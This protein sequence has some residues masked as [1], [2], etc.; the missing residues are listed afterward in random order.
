[1]G[2]ATI[3]G[4]GDH[5][6]HHHVLPSL[7]LLQPAHL[8]HYGYDAEF[9]L[10]P[11]RRPPAADGPP[12][13]TATAAATARYAPGVV[14][15]GNSDNRDEKGQATAGD[16]FGASSSGVPAGRQHHS[17]SP[18]AGAKQQ[19]QSQ[20]YPADALVLQ[21]ETLSGSRRSKLPLPPPAMSARCQVHP[22]VMQDLA[23]YPGDPVLAL[24]L[25]GGRS[26]ATTA[27]SSLISAAAAGSESVGGTASGV[28]KGPAPAADSFAPGGTSELRCLLCTIWAN[29]HLALAE[30]AIDGRI[31][32]PVPASALPVAAPS[33][34]SLPI[35]GAVAATTDCL[36]DPPSPPSD[37]ARATAAESRSPTATTVD[38]ST[39]NLIARFLKA[40]N[41]SGREVEKDGE[42]CQVVGIAPVRSLRKDPGT[43]TPA[44][45][46][47][48]R[49]GDA[50]PPAAGRISARV[51]RSS[52][53]HRG[54]A[55]G[56]LGGMGGTA[57]AAAAGV[58]GGIP[59]ESNASSLP[60]SPPAFEH[61]FQQRQQQR[62]L[63]PEYTSLLKRSLRHLVV[64]DGCE[65]AVPSCPRSTGTILE[66]PTAAGVTGSANGDGGGSGDG[67]GKEHL[68]ADGTTFLRIGIGDKGG[69]DGRRGEGGALTSLLG[70]AVCVV[71]PES[72]VLVES[73]EGRGV[74]ARDS[75]TE[76]GPRHKGVRALD[77]A[78]VGER[79]SPGNERQRG[80]EISREPRPRDGGNRGAGKVSTMTPTEA[81]MELMLLP[82]TATTPAK[83]VGGGELKPLE[84]LAP[85]GVLLTG[86]PGVGKTF[87][88]R[89]AVEAVR[90]AAPPPSFWGMGRGEIDGPFQVQLT[91]LNG[92]EILS[93]G[94]WEACQALRDAFSAAEE[95]SKGE[96]GKRAR[97]N[98][99]A[100][101][102][103][104][105]ADALL[106]R[107]AR[108]SEARD[109]DGD[110][111][112]GGEGA[113]ALAQ[114][115]TLMDGFR[116]AEGSSHVIVVGATNRP[117]ALDPALRRPGRFDRELALAPPDV[118]ER[119]D[120][121]RHHLRRV[122]VA[123]GESTM[124][125]VSRK[126]VGYVGAD[127]AALAREAA[128]LAARTQASR[129]CR[130]DGEENRPLAAASKEALV[131]PE[132]LSLAMEKVGASSL[133]GHQVT[134]P[135][136]PWSDIGGM[137]EAKA[138]LRQAVEWPVVHKASFDRMGLTPP[139]GILLFGPPGCSKTT[140]VRAAA[141][142]A[143]ATFVCLS[144]ADVFSPYLGEAEAEIRQAFRIARNAAPAILFFDEIDAI[145]CNRDGG[146]KASF[147]PASSAESRVLATFL[148]EMDGVGSLKGDGVVV[149]G[150]TNRP[151]A[152]DRALLRP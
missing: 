57:V 13:R 123:G 29:P 35:T 80:E 103:L 24:T 63:P 151:E 59:W 135:D 144:G 104:D 51:L 129:Q 97:G 47:A 53:R 21:R 83:A 86:P 107:R 55:V 79:G 19:Q 84:F 32:I 146:G 42:G 119:A 122:K 140:L 18:E 115:L 143:G 134:V 131:E 26:S 77:G 110:K 56:Y 49:G 23:L 100:V 40:A 52:R 99:C 124:E 3:A 15:G 43:G 34:A 94:Q 102:F 14:G 81:L 61:P 67:G 112:G 78:S 31:H 22:V 147:G 114:L 111:A 48:G 132:H 130:H 4:D 7:L 25:V 95:W 125:T 138:R 58:T 10:P 27:A 37:A 50:S 128:L 87:A 120:I 108:V 60:A 9:S 117:G 71:G 145:V 91:T 136:T 127:L 69:G 106:A 70:G 82:M 65:V 46:R 11:R 88:V 101:I 96:G 92:A 93:L 142:A 39:Q 148:T 62:Y 98:R 12:L 105:E 16:A 74:G 90:N 17:S 76:A 85:R 150:A 68:P 20:Q 118:K 89:S 73:E 137:E 75:D 38:P 6:H 126:C 64:S 141:T 116:G 121:L 72:L 54:S 45:G 66:G 152:V 44:G 109:R 1:M 5:H 133:R 30:T 41:A 113:R 139:R 33:D 28:F 36:A 2:P 149:V 8:R